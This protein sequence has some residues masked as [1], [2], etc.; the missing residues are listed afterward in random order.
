MFGRF[1]ALERYD[2]IFIRSDKVQKKS[3]GECEMKTEEIR[4]HATAAKSGNGGEIES[5]KEKTTLNAQAI[6]KR[7]VGAQAIG[8]LAIGA[9]AFGAV[10]VGA[11]AIGRLVVG[12]LVVGK[13]QVR[14]LE[15]EELSLTS[16]R[17]GKLI[18][19]DELVTP[20]KK[21]SEA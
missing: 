2:V 4:Q 5:I 10:A 14:S 21:D 18:V 19:T 15:I 1:Q 13:S 17:V 7:V 12:R 11:L 20:L 6:G 3:E 16:V 8:S 9:L